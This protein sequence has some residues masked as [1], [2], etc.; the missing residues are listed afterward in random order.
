[1]RFL[2]VEQDTQY[3]ER[4]SAMIQTCCPRGVEIDLTY[5]CD[6]AHTLIGSHN[7]DV[8]F[9]E[10]M[11]DA[12]CTGL[13][14]L[15][16]HN[17]ASSLT[18]FV[19]L[20]NHA[21]KEAAFDALMLGAMDYLIKDRFTP[22]ELAKC[23]SYSMYLKHREVKL[24]TDALRDTLTGLGNK[25]LFKAQLEQAAKRAS[26]DD[27]I[28][29]LLVIDVDGFKAV[30]DQ[31][32]HAV[33]DLL[34]QQIAERIVMETRASDVIARIG[35]DEFAAILIKPKSADHIY[36][37]GNKLEKSLAAMP[38]NLNGVIVKIGASVGSS[39]LPD[40]STNLDDLFSLADTRMY[41]VKNTKRVARGHARDYMDH[42]LR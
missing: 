13:D 14:L 11:L 41:K 32:G 15:R 5:R 9:L 28:L 34:L 22:F 31:H 18:A 24:Q 8:C 19:L 17:H 37:V 42:V 39:I 12:P 1:M 4:L 25:C 36:T 16:E 23:I 7:Y 10:Y 30:N 26:R 27:E 2:L 33:G 3:A 20:T 21:N 38:Y 6:S 35:G 29:G 40:D